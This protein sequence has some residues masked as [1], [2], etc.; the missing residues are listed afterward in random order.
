MEIFKVYSLKSIFIEE[1][2]LLLAMDFGD[3]VPVENIM[4]DILGQ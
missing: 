1:K 4:K 3:S 2:Y